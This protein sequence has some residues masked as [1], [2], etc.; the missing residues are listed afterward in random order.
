MLHDF[1]EII[2]FKPWLNANWSTLEKRFPARI[3]QAMAKQKALSSSA[4]SVTVAEEFVVLFAFT[5]I[6]VEFG[7]YEF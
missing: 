2:M 6:T 7:M 5:F 4:F 1:E 3:I